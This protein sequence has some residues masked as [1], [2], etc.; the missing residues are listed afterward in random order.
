MGVEL[1]FFH[2]FYD[3]LVEEIG[4]SILVD[5]IQCPKEDVIVEMLRSDSGSE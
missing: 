5:A 3:D 2:I 4:G 1:E